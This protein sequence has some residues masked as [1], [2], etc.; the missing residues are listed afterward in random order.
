MAGAQRRP[1]SSEETFDIGDDLP[2]VGAPARAFVGERLRP[3][4]ACCDVAA[5]TPPGPR[6]AVGLGAT[7]EAPR[8]LPCGG[9]PPRLGGASGG[10]TT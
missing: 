1:G 3:P 6:A 5:P 9:E 2:L 8:L 4:T 7:G 10:V